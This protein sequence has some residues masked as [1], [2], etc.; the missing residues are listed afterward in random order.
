MTSTAPKLRK[1]VPTTPPISILSTDA[2]RTFTHIHPVLLLAFYYFRFPFLVAS[3][4]PV[5][6]G[7]LLPVSL[8]QIAY[9]TICLPP[10]N[11]SDLPQ[12]VSKPLKPGQRKRPAASTKLNESV[13]NKI[14]V[15][16][17]DEKLSIQAWGALK[18]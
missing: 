15:G 16:S 10:L 8:I 14:I 18:Y 6:F 1:V 2:A 11:S 12:P 4:V 7:H 17:S 3:P 9:V 5:L 13:W